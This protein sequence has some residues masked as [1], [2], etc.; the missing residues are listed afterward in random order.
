L[1]ILLATDGSA[2][3]DAAVHAVA[4]QISPKGTEVLVLEVVEARGSEFDE[5]PKEHFSHAEESVGRVSRMLA[6]AGFSVATRVIESEPRVAILDLASE[7]HADLIV[8]G[9]HGRK[10]L[11]RLLLGSVAE[12]VARSAHC[13]VL[14]VRTPSET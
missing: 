3:S 14:I 7:W 12:S 5:T 2:F 11:Q 10:G 13:S 1:K 8:L 6:V 4:K 9:S